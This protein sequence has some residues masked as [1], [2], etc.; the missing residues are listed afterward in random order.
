MDCFKGSR[1]C[2]AML[3]LAACPG[4]GGSDGDT[5][6]TT[7]ADDLTT[8][9]P[10][11]TIPL[12]PLDEG[13]SSSSGEATV[14]STDDGTSTGSGTAGSTGPT[15]GSSSSSSSSGEPAETSSDGG[16]TVYEVEWCNIQYPP[17][18]EVE[19]DEVFPVYSHVYVGGLTDQ[20]EFTDPAPELI[21]EVG[22]SVDGSDPSTGVG[23]PW[24]WGTATPNV[25]YN[26]SS[27][28][29]MA[30]NDE[31][32]YDLA[33]PEAGIF[34]YAARIS[35]DSGTTWVYCDLDGLSVGGYTP[36]QAGNA[37]VGQ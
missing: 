18:V 9:P 5:S 15:D 8:G 4:G 23:E 7:T 14:G 16:P 19:V 11:T 20:T 34:D 1:A 6:S 3:L 26:M 33:I 17:M 13:T 24:T 37:A 22:Y 31:Y 36:D 25:G 35:G 10:S 30:N 29:Y 21:V 32:Q 2:V 28:G 12:P 27:P